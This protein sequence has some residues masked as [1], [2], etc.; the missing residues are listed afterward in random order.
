MDVV[1][2]AKLGPYQIVAP[3]GAGGMGEVYRARDTRLNRIV[4]IKVLP[5]HLSESAEARQRF[6]R[7]ALAI[8]SL[9]H[10][11]I[12]HLY[13][14]GQENETSYLV[15]EYLEG[16]TL[17]D[18]LRRGPLA[19]EQF[20]KIGI[21]ICNGLGKAHRSGVI[22]RDLKP[23]N[24]MLTEGGAK[25]MDFGLAKVRPTVSSSSLTAT[26]NTPEAHHV[27]LT[28][29][30]TVVGTFQYM[31]PEQLEGKEPDP[32]SDIFSLGAVLYEMLTGRRAF[33]GKSPLSVASAILGREPAPISTM[34]PM[35]PPALNGTIR[36]CLAKDP[37]E[38]W[39]DARDVGLELKFTAQA[40][41]QEATPAPRTQ[42]RIPR[43]W[44]AA[45]A[46]LAGAL[47]A[48]IVGLVYV[49][50]PAPEVQVLQT[51]ILPPVGGAFVFEGPN[52]GTVLSP[53]GRSVAF[54]VR[55]G[56]VTQ[57]WM[58]SLDSLTAKPL[59]GT[60]D[61]S[62]AF[63]SPDSQNLGFF[64]SGKLKRIAAA[65]GPT[66]TLC[67]ID[68][69]RGGSWSKQNVIIFSKVDGEIYR[70]SASGGSPQQVTNLSASRHE[71]THR[72][73][74]FL[75][76]GNHFLFMASPLGSMN[77]ENMFRLGSL[78]GKDDKVLFQGSSPIMYALG[79]V[80][81]LNEKT[82]MA[83]PFDL[84]K[85]EFTGDAVPIV[86]GV[87][88]DPLWS[89]GLFSVSQNGLL[90]Y[91]EGESLTTYSLLVFD[92]EGKQLSKIGEPAPY[93]VPSFSPDGK[94]LLYDEF[95]ASV[96]KI[97]M[98]IRELAS[99]EAALVTSDPRPLNPVWSPDGER[100]AYSG[101]KTGAPAIYIRP[102]NAMGV[103]QKRWTPKDELAS[104]YDWTPDGKFL[105]VT[106]RPFG[107]GK[108]RIALLT[109]ASDDDPKPILE[110][111]GANIDSGRVSPDGKWI[112]YRSDESGRN[113]IY[114]S[115][116]PKPEGK[117]QI[118]SLGGSSPRW[119][120]DG[121]EVYYLA[122]DHKLMAAEVGNA[123]GSI[124]VGAIRTLFQTA[125][126]LDMYDAAAAG[127]RFVVDSLG[128]GQS[129]APLNLVVNWTAELKKR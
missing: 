81:Y 88:F 82:L 14:V 18:R 32:R 45:N 7:E 72:W 129:P 97:D 99:G 61:A 118:S 21:E 92:R 20:F 98:R 71:L 74:S 29:E 95:D 52:G 102:A 11:N 94:R 43:L 15:M 110:V 36:R 121:K 3:L 49:N 117:L 57:L 1:V 2:G 16:E 91:Q 96:G 22:H 40:G 108:S 109:V 66:Q 126:A 62:F 39:Q 60:E 86:D 73:P 103:E 6:V 65:G 89:N 25:L 12:C 123:D 9:N 75:P 37:E 68:F 105:I 122:P 41:S 35:T 125:V 53:D 54:I 50:K 59:L 19:L 4:A 77:K 124:R 70:I 115:S 128:S 67:D 34:K 87:Q 114:I 127:D 28:A 83:R 107:A 55:V 23:G 106:E 47:V 85:L 5:R 113:E 58:R 111:Q 90:V 101:L 80:L 78:D 17:A 33:E 38:R 63:W 24:V 27:P 13:D 119:R 48:A 112:L 100:I 8:S 51:T 69:N 46:A 10:P 42:R 116:F 56:K 64:A 79:Q 44:I 76:D 31:S 104:P 120:R 84:S 26:F 93:F 30:G